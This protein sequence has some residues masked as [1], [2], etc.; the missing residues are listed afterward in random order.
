ME[1]AGF[2]LGHDLGA[3]GRWA[4]IGIGVLG[5]AWA[6]SVSVRMGVVVQG[7]VY[8]GAIA[9]AY[10]AAHR[11]LGERVLG[12]MNPWVGTVLL[13]G[14]AV[15]IPGIQSLPLELRLG[16]VAY[17]SASMFANAAA[18]YGGCEVLALPSL[19]FGRWYTVYCPLNVI[20]VAERAI[21][22]E[23]AGRTPHR[24]GSSAGR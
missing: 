1:K 14:P 10:L 5:F 15:L 19:L 20:D 21:A 2:T 16:M 3:V 23:A 6:V 11:L 22:G 9:L 17:F 13:V 24:P 12:G 4:R 7:A 18:N 8:V